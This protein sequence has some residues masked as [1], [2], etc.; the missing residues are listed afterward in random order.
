MRTTSDRIRHAV[1]FEVI[2]LLIVTP[3]GAWLFNHP[4]ADIGVVTVISAT[5]AT[6]WNYLY[7]LGFD[8]AM[9]RLRGT[10]QKTVLIRILHAVL[11]EI[12]LL[13][14]LIPFIAWHLQIPLYE[15]FIID[16]AF[17]G[18]YLVYAFVF[19]WLYD[20]IFPVPQ[21]QPA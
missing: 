1:S 14:V 19:N 12:G 7:N 5:I 21:D 3:L 4:L 18:F 6:G 11:F 10:V 16:I 2:A 20:V 17:A 13:F 15:A 9:K 8:H